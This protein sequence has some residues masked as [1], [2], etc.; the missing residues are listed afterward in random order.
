[1]YA[2]PSGRKNRP[3]MPWRNSRGTN[4]MTMMTVANTTA[5]RISLLASKITRRNGL[6]YC[7]GGGPAGGPG[8]SAPAL[9]SPPSPPHGPLPGGGGAG[10]EGG[11]GGYRTA[12]GAGENP[13]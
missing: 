4:T 13:A 3:S 7:G 11:G 6:R 12:R 1:M 5:E 8:A 10:G 9:P 2:I